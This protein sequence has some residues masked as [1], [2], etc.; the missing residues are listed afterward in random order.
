MT[1]DTIRREDL[2]EWS[3]LPVG[4]TCALCGNGPGAGR[5]KWWKEADKPG[6]ARWVCGACYADLNGSA[7]EVIPSPPPRGPAPIP[8]A[9]RGEDPAPAPGRSDPY[10]ETFNA[11]QL[12]V[13]AGGVFEVRAL[14]DRTASGYFDADHL[15]QAA[16][17]IEALDAAGTYSG[18]YVTLNPVNPALLSR[19]SNRIETR[20]GLKEATTADADIIRRRWFPV[21]IDVKRPSGISSTD[22]EHAAA[23]EVAGNVAGFLSEFFG[24]P[25][26]VRADSGNGAHLL[27]R[28]D[29][30]NDEG[31]RTLIERCLKALGAAFD[32]DPSENQPGWEIDKTT[33]N[34]ARIWKLYGTV[35]RK[36]DN[37]P[38]R[39]H[40][41]ARIIEA[42]EVIEVVPRETLER[43]AALAPEEEPRQAPRPRSSRSG[44]DLDEWLKEYGASLPP[45]RAKN[46]P[47]FRSFYVFDV[48]PWDPSHRDRS[49]FMGQFNHGPL[50]AGCHHNGCSGNGWT[51]LRALVEPKRPK[52]TPVRKEPRPLENSPKPAIDTREEVPATWPGGE[53][54]PSICTTGA[55]IHEMT[56]AALAVVNAWNSPPELFSRSAC[57]VRVA[58]DEKKGLYIQELDEAALTGILDRLIV[59]YRVLKDGEVRPAQPPRDVVRDI[60]ALPAAAWRVPHLAGVTA[61][62][63]FHPDGT[64]HATPGY[65]EETGLYY[66]PADGFTLAPVPEVPTREDVAAALKTIEEV[67]VDFPFCSPADRANAIGALLTAVLR[68]CIAGPVPLYLTDKPQ[69]GSGA[70]LLQR[71]IGWIAE[72]REPAL[73]TMPTGP[74]MRK[75]IFASLRNGTR[76]QIFDNLEDRLS[77]P[78][79]A[80]ALTAVEMTG[81]ILGQTEERTYAVRTFW[82]ANGNNVTVGGDLARRTFKSRV[83]PQDPMPWQREGFRHPDLIRWV[84][85]A[86]GR[87]LAAVF[88]LARAWIQAGRPAP[89]KVPRVGSF[90][91]WRDMIGG[92]LESAGVP[93]F[94]GNAS[95]VYLAADEDRTQWE[96]FLQALWKLYGCNPFTTGSVVSRMTYP[97]GVGLLDAMPD[98][99]AEAYHTKNK[100]FSKTLGQAFKKVDG[101]HFPGGWCIRQGKLADGIRQWVITYTDP[102]QVDCKCIVDSG[103]NRPELEMGGDMPEP[104]ESSVFSVLSPI[105]YA[106]EKNTDIKPL[107]DTVIN[108]SENL[109]AIAIADNTLNPLHSRLSGDNR[110]IR[111][112]DGDTG[113]STIHLQSTFAPPPPGTLKHPID[114]YERRKYDSSIV[115]MVPGCK[116]PAA[117][118]CGAGFPLC[119][120]HYLAE[121]E[122]VRRDGGRPA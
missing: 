29:L 114:R 13:P 107:P 8:A 6:S 105:P 81:R 113:K 102:G 15:E 96:N 67:F 106:Q 100:T 56:E 109:C 45:Y 50:F 44:P 35:A 84:Q 53:D 92:I 43:L 4:K 57:L 51:E 24:F 41:R 108:G 95:E 1:G 83:D 23:L 111:K 64:I 58:L 38:E 91:D 101:R 3:G 34:A 33:F 89:E 70:G 5:V 62:P 22:E 25:A 98:D 37:T 47:G 112:S 32:R 61:T 28:I 99:L 60:L 68:P 55:Y 42:P 120:G 73:K 71:V 76:I 93:D 88:T 66:H 39:P 78:E 12:L 54:S 86:R 20:L 75:E 80:A 121:V 14:G 2:I 63:I 119:E 49:A 82:M 97:E 21:D 16:K 72:G 118:G 59:W 122:R 52:P 11:L 17:A 10:V 36:G 46:K 90:E 79:L 115:C 87:I 19:R 103:G 18:I 9:A 110:P 26:P 77:S 65:D 117:Y 104:G 69:A 31:S 74:E 27:Y 94:M 7:A 48:C 30:P 116:R 85:E 40:R